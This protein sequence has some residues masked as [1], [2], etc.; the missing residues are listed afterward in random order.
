[1]VTTPTG[2]VGQMPGESLSNGG[3]S[4]RASLSKTPNGG[5]LLEQDELRRGEDHRGSISHHHRHPSIKN[6]VVEHA[7]KRYRDKLPLGTLYT[8]SG[9][10]APYRYIVYT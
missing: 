4:H 7:P 3:L 5:G 10:N 9:Q 1:M 6:G 8:F 2:G